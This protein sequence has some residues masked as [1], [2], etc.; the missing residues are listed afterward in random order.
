MGEKVGL[1]DQYRSS[2]NFSALFPIP[3]SLNYS[4]IRR[5]IFN[6]KFH[7]PIIGANSCRSTAP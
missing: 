7:R 5:E 2:S 3:V 1:W 6:S 4:L